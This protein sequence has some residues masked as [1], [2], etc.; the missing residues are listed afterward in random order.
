MV[1][2]W[3]HYLTKEV[4]AENTISLWLGTPALV[5][6]VVVRVFAGDRLEMIEWTR[7]FCEVVCIAGTLM[8]AM[9]MVRMPGEFHWS[10]NLL[11]L[12]G[13]LLVGFSAYGVSF[14]PE[15][16]AVCFGVLLCALALYW[17]L[18]S[19]VTKAWP[20]PLSP[21]EVASLC[22]PFLVLRLL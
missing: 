14:T 11:F 5:F 10:I 2:F 19:T 21:V 12:V 22:L 20:Y 1:S 13:H 16:T 9:V 3:L 6:N 15:G 4:Y 18:E 8:T 17:L 7:P